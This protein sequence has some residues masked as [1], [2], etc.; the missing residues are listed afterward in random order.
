M[1]KRSSV[2]GSR[3]QHV[4]FGAES[5]MDCPHERHIIKLVNAGERRYHWHVEHRR[6]RILQRSIR[7]RSDSE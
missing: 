2:R 5:S 6:K 1:S 4:T 7:L 3:V